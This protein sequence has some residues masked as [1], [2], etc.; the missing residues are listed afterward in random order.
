[1]RRLTLSIILAFSISGSIAG[2]S[3]SPTDE[4][5]EAGDDS[6]DES[7]WD[8]K[9][10]GPGS[11]PGTKLV[12][13]G[14]ILTMDE[15]RGNQ[16]VVD[17][18]AVVIEGGKVIKVL[19]QGEALPSGTGVTVLPSATGT[20]NWVITPGLINLHNHLAYNTARIYPDLPLYENT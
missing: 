3:E 19:G 4:E 5:T 16:Q 12:L 8:G 14:T 6:Q 18:G 2:C 17:N 20:S 7:P 9:F 11:T 15:S 13:R 10:D 1:M